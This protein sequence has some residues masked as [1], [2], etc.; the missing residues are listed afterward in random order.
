MKC[1]ILDMGAGLRIGAALALILAVWLL[2][3]EVLA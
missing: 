3:L 2:V 1:G